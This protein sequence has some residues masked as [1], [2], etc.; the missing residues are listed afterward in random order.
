MKKTR[1]L[2]LCFAVALTVVAGC[3]DK[4][5]TAATHSAEGAVAANSAQLPNATVKDAGDA[6]IK[7]LIEGDRKAIDTINH[8]GPSSWPTTHLM[9]WFSEKSQ[10]VG[11]TGIKMLGVQGNDYAFSINGYAF[12]LQFLKEKD[13]YFFVG[14]ESLR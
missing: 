14:V 9:Q 2:V 13:G 8:S 12:K 1:T 7:A 10:A 6:L 3:G 4:A 5:S 11:T